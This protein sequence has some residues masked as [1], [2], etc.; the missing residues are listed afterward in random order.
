MGIRRRNMLRWFVLSL[1]FASAFG[2]ILAVGLWRR[3]YTR[4]D[5]ID[6]GY[7]LVISCTGVVYCCQGASRFPLPLGWVSNRAQ[8]DDFGMI[9]PEGN[10]LG[11]QYDTENGIPDS[12]AVP[13]GWVV[14]LT[15]LPMGVIILT[16]ALRRSR[17][18]DVANGGHLTFRLSLYLLVAFTVLLYIAAR[19]S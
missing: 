3:S 14:F 1:A 16:W 4:C 2:S 8:G 19:L 13:Y 15:S 10:I 11:I 17:K 9:N 6:W 5:Q 7:A 12:L 18:L